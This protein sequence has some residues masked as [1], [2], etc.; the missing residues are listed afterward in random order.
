MCLLNHFPTWYSWLPHQ[1]LLDLR[2]KVNKYYC[3]ILGYDEWEW[4]YYF[5]YLYFEL[6]AEHLLFELYSIA[7]FV[8]DIWCNTKTDNCFIISLLNW[9]LNGWTCK[10]KCVSP[11]TSMTRVSSVH[12]AIHWPFDLHRKHSKQAWSSK[13]KLHWALSQICLFGR[14]CKVHFKY[15]L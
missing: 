7:T 9:Q 4:I 13:Q 3:P 8:L 6:P 12:R 2:D 15:F 14:V 11:K 1:S 10:A 5:I